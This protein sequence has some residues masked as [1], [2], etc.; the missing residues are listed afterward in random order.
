MNLDKTLIVAMIIFF[1]GCETGLKNKSATNDMNNK[2][3]ASGI[4]KDKTGTN[5]QSKT[6]G[7]KSFEIKKIFSKSAIPGYYIQV[8]HFEDNKP[9]ASFMNKIKRTGLPYDIVDKY[10]NDRHIYYAL[11]GPYRSYNEAKS[12]E[13]RGK[14]KPISYGSFIIQAVR[15]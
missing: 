5:V 8:G 10:R 14:T 11:I 9:D 13:E 3:T 7:G 1:T 15:P 4:I 2:A 12:I 6:T